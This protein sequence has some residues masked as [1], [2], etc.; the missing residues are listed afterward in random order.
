MDA[1][2]EQPKDSPEA[3]QPGPS[4]SQEGRRPSL[5]VLAI[6]F[7]VVLGLALAFA[8]GSRTS[9]TPHEGEAGVKPPPPSPSAVVRQPHDAAAPVKPEQRAAPANSQVA[10]QM[11]GDGVYRTAYVN[12]SVDHVATG[13]A[14]AADV[15]KPAGHAE[16]T[17]GRGVAAGPLFCVVSNSAT[18]AAQ[19]P[20]DV[21]TH[22][23]YSD[24]HYLVDEG[25][26]VPVNDQTFSAL[27]L[28]TSTTPQ[29]KILVSVGGPTLDDMERSPPLLT[30]FARNAAGWL[31]S[32][33][34]A[35][36]A[37]IEYAASTTRITEYAA[38]LQAL[39]A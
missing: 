12:V 21:C 27:L 22:L 19:F 20:R 2:P 10:K 6:M 4:P 26:F 24:V 11:A 7:C 34:M 14:P 9:S 1:P 35:G 25:K 32:R 3:E 15:S 28:L 8:L 18:H 39:P 16:E 29:L 38:P 13:G 36:L 33:S 23:I 37:F 17:P 30:R 5:K 31:T